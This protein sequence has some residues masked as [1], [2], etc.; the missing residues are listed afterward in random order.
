[1][2]HFV[3]NEVSLRGEETVA[4]TLTGV[5]TVLM[6]SGAQVSPDLVEVK[7]SRAVEGG[8]WEASSVKCIGTRRHKD[9][10]PY[11]GREIA[12]FP[13][14]EAPAWT[15]ELVFRARTQL[16]PPTPAFAYAG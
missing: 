6:P 14:A 9:G 3:I 12:V 7:F 8:E 10:S 11:H 16:P 2:A 1:M 5:P 15:G 13:I 4:F